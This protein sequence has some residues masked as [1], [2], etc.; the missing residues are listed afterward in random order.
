M[1][2][3][4]IK[5]AIKSVSVKGKESAQPETVV[6]KEV[7]QDVD[8]I[9]LRI[10]RRPEGALESISEKIVYSCYEGKKTVYITVSFMPVKGVVKG[11]EVTIERPVEFFI[12]HGQFGLET[13]WVMAAMRLL[14]RASRGGNTAEALTDMRKTTWERGIVNCGRYANNKP[15][16]HESI[17]AALGWAIQ[18]I[19]ARRGFLREDGT[20]STVE[21]LAA[22]YASRHK[23]PVAEVTSSEKDKSS[24]KVPDVEKVATTARHGE[25]PECRSDNIVLMDGCPTCRDCGHSKCG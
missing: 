11:K 21:E 8:P 18:Q 4:E 5:Q 22:A 1:A 13:P 20:Q 9:T 24:D 2:T 19:L 17:V 23:V 14:T 25:C 16:Q 12:P 6:K 15:V 7:L 10:P 3:H